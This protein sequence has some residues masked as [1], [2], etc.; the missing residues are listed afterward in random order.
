MVANDNPERVEASKGYRDWVLSLL[1]SFTP[2]QP[3]MV[4]PAVMAECRKDADLCQLVDRGLILETRMLPTTGCNGP[5]RSIG[6]S[7][8]AMPSWRSRPRGGR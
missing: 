5:S 1:R 2:S 4:G 3:L 7:P 8:P 6:K